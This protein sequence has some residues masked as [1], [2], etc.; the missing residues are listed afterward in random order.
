V[1]WAV[2]ELHAKLF[3]KGIV[4]KRLAPWYVNWALAWVQLR[5]LGVP[6]ELSSHPSLCRLLS[7]LPRVVVVA[8]KVLR[9]ESPSG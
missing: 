8:F 4:R 2:R 3:R 6:A 5:A 9:G 7:G 1:K